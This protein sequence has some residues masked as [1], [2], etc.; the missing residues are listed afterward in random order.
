MVW[1]FANENCS[2]YAQKIVVVDERVQHNKY[3]N[4]Y[5]L[6]RN[7]H[8]KILY[9]IKKTPPFNQPKEKLASLK[10]KEPS[11]SPIKKQFKVTSKKEEIV[12]DES[13]MQEVMKPILEK[14]EGEIKEFVKPQKNRCLNFQGKIL[15]WLVENMKNCMI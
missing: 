10:P 11:N 15:S 9:P 2:Y 13:R 14:H 12:N 7:G 8:K 3:E 6:M 1:C 5:T 4:N